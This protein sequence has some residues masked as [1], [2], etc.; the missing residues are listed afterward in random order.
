[1]NWGEL[2]FSGQLLVAVPVAL[3]AGFV[4]FAS[5]CVLP[6]V[7]GYLGYVSGSV[8]GNNGERSRSRTVVGALLFVAGFAVVFV[9]Y[10]A[11]FGTL[12]SWLLSWQETITRVLGVV[13]I[14]MGVIF[15]GWIPTLQRTVKPSWMP[16]AGLGGAPLLGVVFGLGWTPCFG[17][18]LAAISALSLDSASAGRGVLLGLVYCLGLGVPFVLI[19]AGSAWSVRS[20]DFLRRNIRQVNQ[21]GGAMLVL[22]GALMVSGVWTTLIY[23]LQGVINGYVL[24]I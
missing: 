7:P 18:T 4:S 9:A 11:A 12:G 6:L 20:V 24:P 10:G 16:A 23:S 19:A 1:V 14:L 15:A 13:I 5:P 8:G 2:A 3:L 17:P 21:I 22:I